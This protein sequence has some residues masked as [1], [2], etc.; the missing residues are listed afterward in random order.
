MEE[1]INRIFQKKYI[2]NYLTILRIIFMVLVIVFILVPI[3]KDLYFLPL[4]FKKS[5]SLT[6]FSI[7]D[8]IAGAFFVIASLTD[9][10]DGFL[11]R[12]YNWV[13]DFGKLWDPLA[14]KLLVNGV[15][16]S[17]S[18]K[19]FIPIWIAV[20]LILRDFVVD[21]FRMEAL[22]K[23][24]IISAGLNGK[25]KTFFEMI[26]IIFIFFFFHFNYKQAIITDQLIDWYLIQN[27][28]LIISVWFSISS[29]I[30]Y[31]YK[32]NRLKNNK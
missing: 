29:M 19:Q 6:N 12:K 32:I 23:K 17:L 11:A 13:S 7:N 2:P 27:L 28:F 5:H 16:I 20:I 1:K 18:Y 9:F 3:N 24:V 22:R 21:A 31:F 26:G 30:Q 15:L 14:D 10:L 25:L 4:N 8:I